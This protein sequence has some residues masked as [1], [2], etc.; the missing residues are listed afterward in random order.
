MD[1]KKDIRRE[2]RRRQLPGDFKENRDYWK[3]KE[4]ELDRALWITR[5]GRSYG[6]VVRQTAELINSWSLKVL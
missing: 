5:F 6:P 4:E 1:R 3:L 2:R